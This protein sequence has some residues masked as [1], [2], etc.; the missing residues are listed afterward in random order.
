MC[1][2]NL[3]W[4]SQICSDVSIIQPSLFSRDSKSLLISFYTRLLFL[5]DKGELRNSSQW[6]KVSLHKHC[7]T[8][9]LLFSHLVVSD[10]LWPHELQHAR[11]PCPSLS[12]WVCSNSCPLSQWCHP[13]IS[14]S[15]TL[16]LLPS[17]CPSIRVFCNE[18]ALRIRWPKYWSFRF[19]TSPSN[20]YSGLISFRKQ[21]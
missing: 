4:S 12:P 6:T 19:S 15:V 14:S 1:P 3:Q 16:L 17:L 5:S 20:E 13:T 2:Y 7:E 10:S 21:G 8:G 18:S 9:L 11:L